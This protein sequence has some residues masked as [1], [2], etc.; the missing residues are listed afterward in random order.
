[1]SRV[2]ER[3][4]TRIVCPIAPGRNVQCEAKAYRLTWRSYDGVPARGVAYLAHTLALSTPLRVGVRDMMFRK[5]Y[6]VGTG[7]RS[8]TARPR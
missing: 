5:N 2:A 6:S 1:M 7:C 3:G 4:A 8:P